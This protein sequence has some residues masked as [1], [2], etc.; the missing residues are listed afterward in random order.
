MD[1]YTEEFLVNNSNP[2]VGL[3]SRD[4]M[5]VVDNTGESSNYHVGRSDYTK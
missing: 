2:T 4:S 5:I 3:L 1:Y